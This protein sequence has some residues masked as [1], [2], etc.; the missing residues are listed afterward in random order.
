MGAL[1][2]KEMGR[3]IGVVMKA[4]AAAGGSADAGKV[5]ALVESK[6]Q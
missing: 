3:A 1:T 4:V 2:K 5:R 6:I